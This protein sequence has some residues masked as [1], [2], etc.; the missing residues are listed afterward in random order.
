MQ[1]IILNSGVGSRMGNL[2]ANKPKCLTELS[3]GETVLERQ[4]KQLYEIGV[5]N[6]IITTGYYDNQ[7]IE[8]CQSLAVPVNITY[9]KNHQYDSTNYI[10]SIFLAKEYISLG[11]D[12]LLMHGDLCFEDTIL[13]LLT[14][15]SGSRMAVSSTVILPEKDFKAVIEDEKI[16]KIG[17]EFFENAIS[18]QPIYKLTSADFETWMDAIENFCNNGKINCYAENAFN[19][20]SEKMSLRTVDVGNL[21]CGEIDSAQDLEYINRKLQTLSERKVYLPFSTDMIH[22]GHIAILKRAAKIGKVVVGVLSDETI[23]SYKRYSIV[24]FAEKKVV[25]ENINCIDSVIEQKTLSLKDVLLSFR[26]DFVIH[27]SDW[28]FSIQKPV[29]EETIEI[30]RKYGGCLIEFPYSEDVKYK[31]IEIEMNLHA[32]IPDVRRG[33]LRKLL[34]LKPTVSIIEAHNGLTGLIAE[35]TIVYKNGNSYQFDGMWISSLCDSTAKGKPDIELI[36]MSSRLRTI[37]DIIEVTTKPIILDGDTGGL[38]EHFIYSVKTL[39]RIGVSAII[40]EDKIG[41]KKNSLFGTDVEQTQ[42]TVEDFCNKIFAGKHAQRTSEFMII[43]RIESL[44]LE[45]GLDDALN[46]AHAYVNAGADGI[47]IH[48]RKKSPDEVF[49]FA[50]LFRETNSTTPLVVVPTSFNEVT[51]DEFAKRNINIVIY[52]NQLIRSAFPA[53]KTTAES[54]LYNRRCKEADTMCLSINE[55]LTLIPE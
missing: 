4:L 28:K 43:A 47:M 2:T 30:L 54:I 24:P 6:I 44:I 14:V 34:A 29:R 32:A 49:E 8:Y 20:V 33:R 16:I 40:I 26:P 35:K 55:I 52:A 7:I 15:H 38:A 9:V 48:S 5:N 51:E 37:E 50:K 1:A 53:M 46:R 22:G 17:I 21:L 39:E 42:D 36:D 41:L 27:G 18:A 45:K 10:Y 3:G 25:F 11:D 12:I 23:A 19:S 31:Q 13:D